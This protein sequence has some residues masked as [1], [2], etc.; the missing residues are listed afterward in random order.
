MSME[1]METVPAQHML[2]IPMASFPG[3][4]SKSRV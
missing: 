4:L 3:V 2:A 1:R